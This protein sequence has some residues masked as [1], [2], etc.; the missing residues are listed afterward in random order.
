MS[1]RDPTDDDY[2]LAKYHQSSQTGRGSFLARRWLVVGA[3]VLACGYLWF[4]TPPV[5]GSLT[6]L[7]LPTAASSADGSRIVTTFA[8][9]IARIWDAATA[10]EVAAL[11]GHEDRVMSAAFSPDG[12]RIITASADKTARIWDT[13]TAKEIA[14]LRGHED[15]VISA[16]FSPDGTRIVTAS[17]DK[18]ARIWD[19]ASGK[20]IAILR[21]HEGWV[22]SAAFSPDGRRILT[23][24][25][26]KTAR[27]WDA[28]GKEIAIL[29]AR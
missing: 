29:R 21:G 18:T 17:A 28:A 11:R 22:I 23:T 8:E 15:S 10:N 12:A 16:A 4:R 27:I 7:M 9:K 20:E 5:P 14:V 25:A 3:L 6:E 13:A 19:T 1:W 2:Q 26:D 24:S